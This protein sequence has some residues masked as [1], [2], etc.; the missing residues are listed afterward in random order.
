MHK[1]YNIWTGFLEEVSVKTAD[2]L[3]APEKNAGYEMKKEGQYFKVYKNGKLISVSST[4]E[5]AR[6][7]AA[8]H[9]AASQDEK[10]TIDKAI[11]VCDSK[12]NK[13]DLV[14]IGGSIYKIIGVR[15]KEQKYDLRGILGGG[16]IYSFDIVEGRGTKLSSF[17]KGIF[18]DQWGSKWE[19]T[20]NDSESYNGKN[21]KTGERKVFKND[22]L[23]YG[24]RVEWK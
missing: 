4:E 16:S 21:I 11:R 24:G 18:T 12:F 7:E 23:R 17:P 14:K 3:D 2:G 5:Q 8:R 20:P 9:R 22:W 13:G 15:E 19:I 10:P 6:R 1:R